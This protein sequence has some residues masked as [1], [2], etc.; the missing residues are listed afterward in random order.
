M[1]VY[2]LYTALSWREGSSRMFGKIFHS[3]RA[4]AVA[5]WIG[6]FAGISAALGWLARITPEWFGALTWPQ[7]ILAGIALATALLLALSVIA[8][9]AAYAFRMLKPLSATAPNFSSD[10]ETGSDGVPLDINELIEASLNEFLATTLRAEFAPHS[11]MHVYDEKLVA[12]ADKLKV[13][14]GSAHLTLEFAQ[15]EAKRLDERI[16]SRIDEQRE[17]QRRMEA[18]VNNLR[19]AIRFGLAGVDQGF[20]AVLN[21]ERLLAKAIEIQNV[22]DELSGPTNGEALDDS[23]VWLKKYNAWSRGVMTWAQIA[24]TYRS[25][26]TE[27]VFETPP[28]E[29]KGEWKAHDGLFPNSNA[30][31]DYK[32]FRIILR[33]FQV[34]RKEVDRC[35]QSAAFVSPSR[36]VRGDYDGEDVETLTLPP[37]SKD[38]V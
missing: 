27:R 33:N 22:G 15:N 35:I 29:Y 16:D 36:K 13:A 24:E 11:Q 37:P 19:Q 1:W 34:E 28:L 31:H 3:P 4:G 14:Q 32:T 2:M 5:N 8:V 30:V 17:F 20:A 25:G 9:I 21:R 38:Q 26:V 12:L 6:I 18:W 23:L 7:T 10:T